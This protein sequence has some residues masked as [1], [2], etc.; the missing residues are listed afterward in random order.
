[1]TAIAG[2]LTSAGT[3]NSTC[4]SSFFFVSARPNRSSDPEYVYSPPGASPNQSH[5]YIRL[6][7]ELD[8][9]ASP[10]LIGACANAV[11]ATADAIKR[12]SKHRNLRISNLSLAGVIQQTA[13]HMA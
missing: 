3:A 2:R 8:T 9:T 4:Q 6:L 1:M 11:D 12:N 10:I 13:H 5:E 7:S